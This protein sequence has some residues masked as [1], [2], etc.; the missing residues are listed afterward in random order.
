ML[1]RWGSA[2]EQV[3]VPHICLLLADVGLFSRP[4][5]YKSRSDEI[6]MAQHVSAGFEG[7]Q[8]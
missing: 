4:L 5:Q 8:A 7:G 1:H 2:K 3:L 6:S